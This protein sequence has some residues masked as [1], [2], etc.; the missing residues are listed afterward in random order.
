MAIKHVF[1]LVSERVIVSHD[2]KVSFID[3]IANFMAHEI[4]IAIGRMGI[5]IAIMGDEGDPYTVDIEGPRGSGMERVPVARGKIEKTSSGPNSKIVSYQFVY[6]EFRP[7]ILPHEGL[8]H[9]VIRERRKVVN[10]HPFAVV[11]AKPKDVTDESDTGT[12]EDQSFAEDA[13]S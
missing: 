2:K 11:L 5:G 6:T 1:T 13:E 9:I 12:N 8:Y 10:R 3:L 7:I 4:P